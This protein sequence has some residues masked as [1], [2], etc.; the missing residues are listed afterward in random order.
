MAH[1]AQLN[2]DS[3]V[4][5]VIVIDNGICGE[6][7]LHFPD[8]EEHGRTFIAEVLRLGGVWRQTSY[9]GNFRGCYAGIGFKYDADN[10]LFVPL[11]L[12]DE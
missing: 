6:P 9:N 10:D 12:L 11:P 7:E 3:V 8:T 5:Q 1:F 2:S 4:T